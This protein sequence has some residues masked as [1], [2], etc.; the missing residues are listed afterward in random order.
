LIRA[1]A[2]FQGA[3]AHVI[4]AAAGFQATITPPPAASTWLRRPDV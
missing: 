4:R 3:G 2:G 1:A